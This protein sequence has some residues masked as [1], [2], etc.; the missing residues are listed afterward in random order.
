MHLD[1]TLPAESAALLRGEG[2]GADTAAKENLAGADDTAIA[3]GDRLDFAN[4]QASPSTRSGIIVRRQKSLAKPAV[5]G[6]AAQD[7]P[8]P[9]DTAAGWGALDSR[10][11]PHTVPDPL[12]KVFGGSAE[13]WLVQQ[14]QYDLTHVRAGRLK[15]KRLQLA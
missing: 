2:F 13:S 12:S 14:A 8:G 4:I 10:T 9:E 7:Y 6:L 3:R 15:L 1:K 5:L 11:R